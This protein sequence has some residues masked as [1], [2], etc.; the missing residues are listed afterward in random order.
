MCL[1]AA[2]WV[3][4]ETAV[5]VPNEHGLEEGFWHIWQSFLSESRTE[6]PFKLHLQKERKD[7][8]VCDQFSELNASPWVV[9][10]VI[11][12]G[13]SLNINFWGNRIS[14]VKINKT[15]LRN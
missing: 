4:S 3:W 1:L 7:G 6:L 15:I 8:D 9:I 11:P 10:K 2:Q 14:A 5:G 13:D 12:G